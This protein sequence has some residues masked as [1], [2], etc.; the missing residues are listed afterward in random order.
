MI[1][2]KK[3]KRESEMKKRVLSI[4]ICAVMV[5]VMIPFVS[6]AENGPCTE[7]R[8]SPWGEKYY[9]GQ[10]GFF[11]EFFVSEEPPKSYHIFSEAEVLNEMPGAFYD[12]ETNTLFIKDVDASDLALSISA[13]GDDFKLVV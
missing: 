11:G 5:L 3:Q 8:V 1:C 2:R 10:L 6:N 9:P 13:M 7:Q 12:L 4:F